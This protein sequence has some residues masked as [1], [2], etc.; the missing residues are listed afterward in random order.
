MMWMWSVSVRH[1][2]RLCA[3]LANQVTRV[4]TGGR[5]LRRGEVEEYDNSFL[6]QLFIGY[7]KATTYFFWS[8]NEPRDLH[9]QGGETRIGVNLFLEKYGWEDDGL[10]DSNR[11][12]NRGKI[13]HFAFSP[14]W[15]ACASPLTLV[16]RLVYSAHCIQR[17]L[18]KSDHIHINYGMQL[19]IVNEN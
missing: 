19:N 6:Y 15:D 7:W 2:K 11:A 16:T 1:R 5:C 10:H 14:H 4:E 8:S 12:S 18:A 9:A 13:M 3:V 17:F